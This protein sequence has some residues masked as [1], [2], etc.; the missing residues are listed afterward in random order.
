MEF[1]DLE[2]AR[3]RCANK[4]KKFIYVGLAIFAAVVLISIIGVIAIRQNYFELIM[5]LIVNLAFMFIIYFVIIIFATKKEREQYRKSYKAYFIDR[6]LRQIF[7]DIY[8]NHEQGM[9]REVLWSTT[10]MRTGDLYSSN[11]YTSGK[12]KDVSFAQADIDIQEEHTDSD[13]GTTYVRIFKGRW[14]VFEFPKPFTFRLEV[15]QKH[16]RAHIKL[17]KNKETN[18]KIVEISTESP[19]FNKKF[20]VYAEDGFE[21]YYILD[22]AYIDHI[23]KLSDIYKG[24]MLLCFIDNKLHV[25]IN[26]NKDAFEPPSSLKPLDEQAENQ[27]VYKDIKAVTDFVDFLKLDRKLFKN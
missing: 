27:K 10:M 24:E 13:G 4:T 21:A 6:N 26:N 14:M 11:D 15:V 2:L 17:R 16:F 7:T 25:A 19:T 12:Y 5:A 22:P 8:Y 1:K 18:R 3:E 23:E 20:K 9:P